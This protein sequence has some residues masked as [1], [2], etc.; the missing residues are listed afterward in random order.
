MS[1]KPPSTRRRVRI[2]RT[3]DAAVEDVWRLW[4]TKDGIESW[5]GPD[6]FAVQ[7]RKIDLQ[8]GGE[9][10]Y[11][12]TARA[13]DQIEFLEKAGMPLTTQTRLVYKDV[14]PLRR[15]AYTQLADFIP[16]VPTY[17]VATEVELEVVGDQVRMTLT[18]DAMHDEQ[19]TRLAV[20]GWEQEL[21]KL[22]RVLNA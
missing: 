1:S 3:Y 17:D 4:T 15:L 6:G 19:W 10:V 9:L 14:V 20:M 5:W 12:M 11:A 18:F 13:P 22:A 2:E 16:G 21:Q 7:V 8:P